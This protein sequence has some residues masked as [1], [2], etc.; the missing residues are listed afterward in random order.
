MRPRS[1]TQFGL[2]LV[3]LLVTIVVLGILLGIG[4]PSFQSMLAQNRAT[5]VANDLQ[6]TL[7]FARSTAIAQARPVIVCVANYA[8]DP[9]TC[10]AANGNWHNG[11]IVLMDG[12]I[13]RE[14]RAL[15]PSITLTGRPQWE[16]TTTGTLIGQNIV[17]FDLTVN[18]GPGAE[19]RICMTISGS[20]RIIPGGAAC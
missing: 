4:V 18:S 9:A 15:N 10:S 3:E 8:N 13:L 12:Q 19:R 6:S 14:H 17:N 1:C 11:W 5:S 16:Y 7:Q 20:S 2:T